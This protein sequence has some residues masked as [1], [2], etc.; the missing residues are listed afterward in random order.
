MCIERFYLSPDLDSWQSF[1]HW[2]VQWEFEGFTS[3]LIYTNVAPPP[4]N[5]YW[6]CTWM[7]SFIL[8]YF[9]ALIFIKVTYIKIQPVWRWLQF[10]ECLIYK[11]HKRAF[12]AHTLSIF[13]IPKW[14]PSILSSSTS[15]TRSPIQKI[16]PFSTPAISTAV[17][18]NLLLYG[19]SSRY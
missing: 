11:Q 19:Y 1:S 2:N 4:T 8:K 13:P 10:H 15:P 16:I 6:H 18:Q 5:G 3:F 14:K 17:C 12:H 7:F 9:M